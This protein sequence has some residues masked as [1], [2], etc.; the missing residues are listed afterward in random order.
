M[1]SVKKTNK[2]KPITRIARILLFGF[3]GLMVLVLLLTGYLHFDRDNI[4]KRLL[5]SSNKYTRGELRFE[6]I[7][8][9]PFIC[10]NTG[11]RL[12]YKFQGQET[13]VGRGNTGR[14]HY[15]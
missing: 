4:S 15:S 10:R 9:N 7:A 14:E 8:F 13:D 12:R 3:L 6:S 2:R 1:V 11:I 5:L